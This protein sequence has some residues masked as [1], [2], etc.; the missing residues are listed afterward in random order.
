MQDQVIETAVKGTRNVMEACTETGVKR[1]VLTSS[2]GAIYMDAH[3]DPL[4]IVNENYWSDLDYCIQTKVLFNN[5][6]YLRCY[7][8]TL[9]QLF[10]IME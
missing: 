2:I 7:R 9:N 6:T 10:Q 5:N 1:I 8:T 4:A 3:R